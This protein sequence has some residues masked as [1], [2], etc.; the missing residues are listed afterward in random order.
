MKGTDQI[1]DPYDQIPFAGYLSDIDGQ[2][3]TYWSLMHFLEAE[4]MRGV[5][6]QYRR[7]LLELRDRDYFVMETACIGQ[8]IRR[9]DWS[10][11]RA[12]V[13]YAGLMMQLAQNKEALQHS[14][15]ADSFQCEAEII[16]EVRA[17]LLER[18]RDPEPLRR[19]L[20]VGTGQE[21]NAQI[22]SLFDHIFMKRKPDEIITFAEPGVCTAAAKYAHA[23]Y[24]PFRAFSLQEDLSAV[25]QDAVSRSSHVFQIGAD[26][27]ATPITKIAF[28]LACQTKKTAHQLAWEQ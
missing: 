27:S 20:F 11:V 3:E 17:S 4:K 18:L 19:V 2:P 26:D 28:D 22:N 13:I 15:L 21:Q 12:S 24:I 6:D 5:D 25:A 16:T 14:L 10:E 1:Y 8:S 7:Y 9:E 23:H